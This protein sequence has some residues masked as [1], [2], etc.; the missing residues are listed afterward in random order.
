MSK[1]Q[2]DR[3]LRRGRWVSSPVRGVYLVTEFADDPVAHLAAATRFPGALAHRRS[4]LALWGLVDHPAKPQIVLD[5]YLHSPAINV[6]VQRSLVAL[7]R[8][9]RVGIPTV[10]LEFGLASLAATD[11][12]TTLHR[13]ID[14]ALR[15]QLTTQERVMDALRDAASI[16]RRGSAVLRSILAE[17]DPAAVVPL[18]DWSRDVADRLEAS[19]LRRPE[20]EWRVQDCGGHLVAQVDLAYPAAKYAIELDSVAFHLDRAAFERD[21]RRDIDLADLGWHVDRFTWAMCTTDW[22]W[23]VSTVSKRLRRSGEQ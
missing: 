22:P 15:R 20:M 4:T 5:R 11:P 18:S 9:R 17:R 16:T 21:R 23:I 12:A 2:V 7:P 6:T 3:R 8:R 10:S 13:L 19:E 14:E 1:A